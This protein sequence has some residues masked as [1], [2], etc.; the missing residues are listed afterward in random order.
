MKKLFIF[1]LVFSFAFVP[2]AQAYRNGDVAAR[3]PEDA[4]AGVFKTAIIVGGV[5]LAIPLV[6]WAA[7]KFRQPSPQQKL[8]LDMKKHIYSSLKGRIQERAQALPDITI[9]RII[10]ESLVGGGAQVPPPSAQRPLPKPQ[11]EELPEAYPAPEEQSYNPAVWQPTGK[12]NNRG[13]VYVINSSLV[14][15]VY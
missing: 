5:L 14:E 1:F 9:D 13:G 4:D 8:E 2:T 12:N 3:Y 7:G 6:S 15:E 10:V 11:I